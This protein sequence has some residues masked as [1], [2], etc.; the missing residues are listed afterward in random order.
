M[1][2]IPLGVCLFLEAEG[3]Y[4]LVVTARVP[5][6]PGMP[7]F[8]YAHPHGPRVLYKKESSNNTERLLLPG[9]EL[10]LVNQPLF[11]KS[12]FKSDTVK[13]ALFL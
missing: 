13:M 11:S 9:R 2:V 1:D 10:P 7:K 12:V 3:D 5:V 8:R 6:G 4:H